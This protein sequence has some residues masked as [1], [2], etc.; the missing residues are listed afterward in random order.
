MCAT[1]GCGNDAEHVGIEGQE[2]T[3]HH[4]HAFWEEGTPHPTDQKGEMQ[5]HKTLEIDVLSVNNQNAQKNRQ[6]FHAHGITAIQVLSSPGSGKTTL[7]E[8]TV[9][10]LQKDQI[11]MGVLVGDQRTDRDAERLRQA[12]CEAKQITTG[13]VCH[14]DAHMVAHAAD[15]LS[16]WPDILFIEN[17]GNLICPALFDLGEDARVVLLSVTEGEDKPVKYADMFV[18]ADLVLVTKVDLLPYLDISWDN[19]YHVINEVNPGAKIL[20]VSVKTGQGID[21]WIQWLI[22]QKERIRLTHPLSS[23]SH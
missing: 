13:S 7:L 11:T 19:L 1:C 6:A 15:H 21:E 17:V 2:L 8:H 10:R 23:P 9:A 5:D 14:L 12:G 4:H 22:W 20:P 18:T 3:A 16:S